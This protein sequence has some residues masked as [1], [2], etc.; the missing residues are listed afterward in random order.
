MTIWRMRITCWIT[1]ATDTDSEYT[2]LIAYSLQKWL[3][4]R[5]SLL[6][7]MYIDS[8]VLIIEFC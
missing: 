3:H 7:Y 1:M 4:E 2:T 6:R 5:T 8:P